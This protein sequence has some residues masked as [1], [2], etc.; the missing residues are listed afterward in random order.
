MPCPLAVITRPEIEACAAV[1]PKNSIPQPPATLP[2]IVGVSDLSRTKRFQTPFA[3]APPKL[4][5]SVC[6]PVPPTVLPGKLY[7]G[8]GAG[9]GNAP[10]LSHEV[11]SKSLVVRGPLSGTT[12][13]AVS[14]KLS[15][16]G[17]LCVIP[18][19]AASRINLAPFGPTSR[20]SALSGDWLAKS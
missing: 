6:V 13:P 19:A 11:G 9:A 12:A 3:F 7:G 5:K 4:P 8:A 16:A 17:P 1:D 2:T 18:P 20:K 14:M 15:V 10:T